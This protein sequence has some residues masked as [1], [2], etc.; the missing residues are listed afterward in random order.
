MVKDLN[1]ENLNSDP[2]TLISFQDQLYFRAEH[3]SYYGSALWGTDGSES[4]ANWILRGEWRN[5]FKFNEDFFLLENGQDLFR[6]YGEPGVRD[7][8]SIYGSYVAE[9]TMVGNRLFFRSGCLDFENCNDSHHLWATDGTDD[10]TMPFIIINPSSDGSFP[11]Q[12]TNVNDELFFT[13]DDGIHGRQVWHTPWNTPNAIQLTN[14]LNSNSLFQLAAGGNGLYFLHTNGESTNCD[15]WFSNGSLAGTHRV[16]TLKD[17]QDCEFEGTVAYKQ[18][19]LFF[20][21]DGVHGR[22]LWRSDGSDTG[23]FLVADVNPGEQS[24]GGNELYVFQDHVYFSGVNESGAELW[25]TDGSPQGTYQV[26]D[27]EPGT[28]SSFPMNML[29]FGNTMFFSAYDSDHGYELW[30][31]DGT[32]NGTQFVYD[33]F[34]GDD[35]LGPKSSFPEPLAVHLQSQQGFSL[36]LSVDDG[37]HGRELWAYPIVSFSERS[38]LP[39]IGSSP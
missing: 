2:H 38:H 39:M 30:Q 34:D 35:E 15:L 27:I 37:E 5:A 19:F 23:T 3:S 16:K 31:T 10:G 9:P 24:G 22:E 33:F 36:Y 14:L 28:A 17:D 13:A 11:E 29:A 32:T 20:F 4:N 12:L 21:D 7:Y 1:P 6:S 26:K 25:V 8:M 18:M